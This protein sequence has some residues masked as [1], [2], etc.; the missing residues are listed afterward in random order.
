MPDMHEGQATAEFIEVLIVRE[1]FNTAISSVF[2]TGDSLTDFVDINQ[3]VTAFIIHLDPGIIFHSLIHI[4]QHIIFNVEK[5]PI[6]TPIQVTQIITPTVERMIRITQNL[7]ITQYIVYRKENRDGGNSGNVFVDPEVVVYQ[8]GL[9]NV[10]NVIFTCGDDTITIRKPEFSDTVDYKQFRVQRNTLGGA[11]QI[12]KDSMWPIYET[13]DMNWIYL[14]ETDATALL[15]YLQNTIG[16]KMT[17]QN[18]FGEVF[19]GFIITPFEHILQPKRVGW[20]AEFTFQ[21][22]NES[23]PVS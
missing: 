8:A 10:G 16:K 11:L 1:N 15:I 21:V 20:S 2:I 22:H 4:N 17:F 12:Y 18:H 6:V 5:S 14:N 23:N 3:I 9:P 19:L 13:F 7:P